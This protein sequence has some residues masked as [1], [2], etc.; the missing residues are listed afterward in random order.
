MRGLERR[1]ASTAAYPRAEAVANPEAVLQIARLVGHAEFQADLGVRD[2]EEPATL[3]ESQRVALQNLIDRR[4]GYV[5]GAV[6]EEAMA[7]DDVVDSATAMDYLRDRLNFLGDL[8]TAEQRIRLTEMF[9][10]RV[11]AWSS[12]EDAR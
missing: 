6:L 7:S 3:T 2:G 12:P 9:E 5:L 4:I 1:L 10:G 8:M 11:A